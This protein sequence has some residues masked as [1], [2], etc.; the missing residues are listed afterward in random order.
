MNKLRKVAVL[1][2][3]AVAVVIG[4]MA[5]CHDQVVIDYIGWSPVAAQGWD[6]D[7]Y[8]TK[9]VYCRENGVENVYDEF[10]VCRNA[11]PWAD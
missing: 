10:T 6:C 5:Q 11:W 3:V 4:L 7:T 1:L 9:S 8:S 2:A